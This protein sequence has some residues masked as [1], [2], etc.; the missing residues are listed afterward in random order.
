MKNKSFKIFLLSLATLAFSCEVTNLEPQ[1]SPNAL[2]SDQF[3][4]DLFITSIERNLATYF[5]GTQDFGSQLTRQLVMFGP[6]YTNEYSP[7]DMDTPWEDAYSKVLTDVQALKSS[8][9][10]KEGYQHLGI[11]KIIEAYVL[12]TLVDSFGDIPYSEA[13]KGQENLNPK[14]D[15]G[16]DVYEIARVLLNEGIKDLGNVRKSKL[17]LSPS[18]D[19][20]Y[21]ASNSSISASSIGSFNNWIA[22]ANTL[23]IRLFLNYKFV[24]P[25]AARDSIIALSTRNIIDTPAEDFQFKYSNTQANPDSRHPEFGANYDNGASDYMSNYFMNKLRTDYTT[26]D[27]RV[28]Y[29]FYRQQ[30]TNS[31]DPNQLPCLGT[32][33]PAWYSASDPYC[34]LSS[35]YW[36][37]DH[38]DAAG[39]P[40]DG[41]RRTIWGIYPVGGRFD[42]SAGGG[43]TQNSGARGAGISPMMLSFYTHFMLAEAALTLGTG[44]NAKTLLDLANDQA[45]SKVMGFG[46]EVG[47]TFTSTETG[48]VP[49]TATVNAYKAAV[50]ARYNAATTD[51]GRLQVVI[52]EFHKATYGNGFEA[53]NMYRRTGYPADLQPAKTA[54]DPGAFI[55][56]FIY[57]ANYVNRNINAK[58]KPGFGTEV[59]VFW[60]NGSKNLK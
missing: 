54:A 23:K 11:A 55:R 26:V 15:K 7:T 3:S 36:G 6:L 53:Y 43:Q 29:Y 4:E 19:L 48:F 10:A 59:L 13:F 34:Q 57:P 5:E 33:K 22:L 1:D 16:S 24:A 18:Y 45:I 32:A 51:E 50:T 52:G 27:P 25:A 28:R 38:G 39:I 42:S 37:R 40:P 20:I 9:L 14:A 2:R 31:T 56:S 21:G 12:L 41:Q 44:A 58:Q 60:D 35:G 8:A 47:Y 46:T 49:S 17:T 30:T